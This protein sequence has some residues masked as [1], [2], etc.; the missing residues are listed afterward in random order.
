[1]DDGGSRSRKVLREMEKEK[2]KKKDLQKSNKVEGREDE[3][4]A[5]RDKGS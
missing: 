1:M 3:R 4:M 2:K 5:D